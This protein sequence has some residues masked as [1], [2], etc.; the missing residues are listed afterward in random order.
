MCGRVLQLFLNKGGVKICTGSS[1]RLLW[2]RQWTFGF[3]KTQEI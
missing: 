1:G 2:P 3:Y